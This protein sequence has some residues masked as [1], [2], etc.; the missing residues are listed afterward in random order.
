M[1]RV[2]G[3]LVVAMSQVEVVD[4]PV[5][6]VGDLIRRAQERLVQQR[7]HDLTVE[8]RRYKAIGPYF[9]SALIGCT[10]PGARGC[11]FGA[12]V[13]S[14]KTSAT[15]AANSSGFASIMSNTVSSSASSSS[16]MSFSFAGESPSLAS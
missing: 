10:S 16:A 3:A 14:A 12:G 4:L 13:D 5:G 8:R 1:D 15:L 6:Q 11:V 7:C 2:G 9:A